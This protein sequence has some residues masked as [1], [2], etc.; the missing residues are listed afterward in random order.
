MKELDY[1]KL[2][3]KCGLEIHQQID[4]H[5]LFC[6]CPSEIRD[7][8]PDIKV[9]RKLR[10]VIGE[11]GQVDAAAA[12]TAGANKIFVY[13]G[14]TDSTCPIEFDE[15]P[16]RVMNSDA[17]NMVIQSSKLLNCSIVDE[18]QVM[19]KIVV[20]GSNTSG[21]QRTSLVGR[22]GSLRTEYGNVGIP[23]IS[24]EEDSAKIA[25]RDEE[26]DETRYNLSRL[27]IPL[28]EIGTAPDITS[29]EMAKFVAAELGMILRSTG[30][31][32]RGLGTIRQD[33]NVSIVGGDRI[34]IKGA[35][36]LRMIPKW[37][38]MEVIRQINLIEIKDLLNKKK[39]KVLK[40][41][42]DLTSIFEKTSCKIISS[43]LKKE[44]IVQGI[45]LSKFAGYIGTE[46]QPGRR[47]GTEFSDY[48][49]KSAGVKGLI[50]SDEDIKKYDLTP[51][52]VEAVKSELKCGEDD[53]Y[54][55]VAALPDKVNIALNAIISRAEMSLLCV[56][57]EVRKSNPDGTTS[58]MR[59][60]P[61]AARMYPE[62]DCVPIPT[63]DLLKDLKL[64]ELISDK[65][66]RYQEKYSLNKEFADQCAKLDFEGFGD[67]ISN[68]DE[69]MSFFSN[70]SPSFVAQTILNTPKEVK[71][72]FKLEFKPEN[73]KDI[74]L[75]L[76]K[77]D[78]EEI[79]KEALIDILP[80]VIE[81]KAIDYSKYKPVDDSIIEKKVK[82]I[83]DKNKGAPFGALMG[84]AMAEF[85]GKVDGKKI[86]ELLKKLS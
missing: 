33:L 57:R 80:N 3:L 84:K 31:V 81:G 71:K 6:N 53:A 4:T 42:H 55:M 77:V 7:D 39:A 45:K 22:H 79:T 51:K 24:V 76:E 48:A 72:R 26:S 28:I 61:G 13:E 41:K 25:N 18:V 2:G 85:R 16:P 5:K 29:P 56:P 37:T 20:D 69:L 50:H 9:K 44:G 73:N 30:K 83:I 43:A 82:E 68:F 78:G 63:K 11:N 70:I 66:K 8:V 65:A 23:D 12:F 54:I 46:V 36:D 49:K 52:E 27:G 10:A 59:P 60:M 86:S 35:Q 17:L 14:Y 75:L 38:E 21:F 15:E 32:K 34:E 74:L 1:K 64:P 47:L 67:K 19:R 58:F 62:T 40:T